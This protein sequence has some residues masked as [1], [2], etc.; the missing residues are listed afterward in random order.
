MRAGSEDLD[1]V[2]EK[3][4]KALPTMAVDLGFPGVTW[5]NPE[6]KV[7]WKK[8]LHGEQSNVIAAISPRAIDR[9]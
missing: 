3:G 4:L 7:E 6:R 8:V 1:S 5:Q 9:D 2:Y